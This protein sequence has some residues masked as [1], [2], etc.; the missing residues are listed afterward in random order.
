MAKEKKRVLIIDDE[1]SFTNMVKLHLER[2]NRFEVT[3]ANDPAAGLSSARSFVP[4][5][6]LL[7][8][9]MPGQDGG[10]VLAEIQKDTAL[11]KVPV[12]FLTATMSQAGLKTRHGNIGGYPFLAKPVEPRQLLQRIDQS[13]AQARPTGG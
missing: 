1:T 4:D 7:D 8:V 10:E 6:I 9:V 13:L 12:I 2:T 5:L 11:Q 3:E